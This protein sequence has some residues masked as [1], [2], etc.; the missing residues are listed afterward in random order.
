MRGND[1]AAVQSDGPTKIGLRALE[2]SS[3]L[4]GVDIA[5]DQEVHRPARRFVSGQVR[6]EH[7][8]STESWKPAEMAADHLGRPRRV[9]DELAKLG[10]E[11]RVA[12]SGEID[13][14]AFPASFKDAHVDE[15]AQLATRGTGAGVRPTL[16]LAQMQPLVGPVDQEGGDPPADARAPK[17]QIGWRGVA[18]VLSHENT[19]THR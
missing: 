19:C 5:L 2:C 18:S 12:T 9:A 13:L 7:G 4:S 8:G 6:P 17:E 10:V 14:Q 15:S 3:Q 1:R 11:R 16:D